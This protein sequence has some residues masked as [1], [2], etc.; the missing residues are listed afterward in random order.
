MN[1]WTT[2]P[3]LFVIEPS[4]SKVFVAFNDML[5]DCDI[6]IRTTAI[7][8]IATDGNRVIVS[9]DRLFEWTNY[10]QAPILHVYHFGV[11]TFESHLTPEE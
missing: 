11:K 5:T 9:A 4:E 1:E 8:K 3:E 6:W 10:K 2:I 7:R